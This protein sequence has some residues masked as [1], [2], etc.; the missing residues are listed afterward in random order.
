MYVDDCCNAIMKCIFSKSKYE[1][2]NIGS[3]LRITNLD[4]AK[5][6][7]KIMKKR[8]L[9]KLKRNNFLKNV[10]DRPGHDIRY[11][12]NS[13]KIKSKL[14]W[15]PKI[16]FKKGIQLT[17]DWYHKNRSYYNSFSKKDIVKRLGNI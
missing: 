1:Q 9:T 13:N 15:Y 6:L 14:G 8:N 5:L 16:N 11:A 2:L 12:L 7:F 4:L 3:G 10:K 17:F